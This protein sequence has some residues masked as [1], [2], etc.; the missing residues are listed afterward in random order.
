MLRIL[1]ILLSLLFSAPAFAIYKCESNGQVTYRDNP[2]P[3]G[4]SVDLGEKTQ[5]VPAADA[6]HE[7]E[8][9]G[10]Q[11][12][13]ADRLEKARHKR[14]TQEEKTQHIAARAAQ[15]RAKKCAAL[16]L[17]T[18]WANEDAASASGKSAEKSKRKARRT[19]ENYQMQCDNK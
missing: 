17:H 19:A 18:K 8:R 7:R 15:A 6:T 1:P 9:I 4:K 11:K 16:A 10:Q 12:R 13:E 5:S 2:C 14:E 3:S